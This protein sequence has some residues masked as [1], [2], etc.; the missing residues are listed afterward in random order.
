MTPDSI[1][2]VALL[3]PAFASSIAG[4]LI[5]KYHD[6]APSIQTS[7]WR[8]IV[9]VLGLFSMSFD[10][11]LSVGYMVYKFSAIAAKWSVFDTCSSVGATACLVGLI[12]AA[13]GKGVAVR[14]VLLFGSFGGMLFWYLTIGPP[15]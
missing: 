11:A 6:S 14:L 15:S 5:W 3:F 2:S 9:T 13:A 10:A 8:R 1:F 12:A 7:I 4:W